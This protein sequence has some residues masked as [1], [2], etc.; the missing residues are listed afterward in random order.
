MARWFCLYLIFFMFLCYNVETIFL[1]DE[2]DLFKRHLGSARENRYRARH[3]ASNNI[4]HYQQ[5]QQS[6]LLSP[7]V[8]RA[9]WMELYNTKYKNNQT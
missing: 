6:A 7:D 8:L 5:Q 1:T 9:R 4:H 2:Y 3:R